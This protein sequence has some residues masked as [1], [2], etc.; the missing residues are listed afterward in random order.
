MTRLRRP[1]D[2][3][4]GWGFTGSVGAGAR[5]GPSSGGEARF[6]YGLRSEAAGNPWLLADIPLVAKPPLLCAKTGWM[7]ISAE[8]TTLIVTSDAHRVKLRGRS[9]AIND[10]VCMF[11]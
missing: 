6:E 8:A 3:G 5:A 9:L 1:P 7:P 4:A 2:S 11:L 10:A